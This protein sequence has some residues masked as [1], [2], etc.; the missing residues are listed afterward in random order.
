MAI[1]TNKSATRAFRDI[2][3]NFKVYCIRGHPH[4]RQLFLAIFSSTREGI[5]M[6]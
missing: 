2:E 5:T 4:L 1:A 6:A 3:L